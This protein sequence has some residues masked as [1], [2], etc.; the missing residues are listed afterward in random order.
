M[1]TQGI[2]VA[3]PIE[4]YGY[5]KALAER[6]CGYCIMQAAMKDAAAR[7]TSLRI[8]TSEGGYELRF[9]NSRR[10]IAFVRAVT[11]CTCGKGGDEYDLGA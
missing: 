1:S 4:R 5:K 6:R 8:T 11:T 3:I 2:N 10:P 9:N 7:K